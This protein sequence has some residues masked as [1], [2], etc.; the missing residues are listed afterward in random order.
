[1]AAKHDKQWYID[2]Y[3]AEA[4]A[5]WEKSDKK[6]KSTGGSLADW[7]LDLASEQ[8][9]GKEVSSVRQI[10]RDRNADPYAQYKGIGK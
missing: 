5:A 1:M 2:K 10:H 4:Q 7:A 9:Q 8:A 3:G 6:S